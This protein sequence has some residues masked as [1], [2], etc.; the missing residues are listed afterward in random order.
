MSRGKR[1]L[2]G[3][4]TDPAKTGGRCDERGPLEPVFPATASAELLSLCEGQRLSTFGLWPSAQSN[5]TNAGSSRILQ[6]WSVVRH[7]SQFSISCARANTGMGY[8]QK[9]A[10]LYEHFQNNTKLT[11]GLHFID[12]KI[13]TSRK[14]YSRA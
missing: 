7:I 4:M 12:H 6:R 1:Y 10:I 13:E 14:D 3:W 9:S 11:N 5:T 2:H 8:R